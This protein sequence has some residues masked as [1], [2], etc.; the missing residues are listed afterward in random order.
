MTLKKLK[1]LLKNSAITQDEFDEMVA[2]L[3]PEDSPPTDPPSDPSD[4]ANPPTDP[5]EDD[6]DAKIT[7][8]VQAALGQAGKENKE[9]KTQLKLERKKNLTAEELKQVELQEKEAEILKKEQELLNKENRMYAIKSLKKGGLDDGGE[10]ALDFVDFVMAEDETGIDLKVKA[11]SALV[12]KRVKVEVE[13]TF[14]NNGRDPGK[15]NTSGEK[16]NPW[17]KDNWNLTK[18]MKMELENPELA[19]TMKTSAIR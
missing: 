14:R 12:N 7:K 16:G 8:A 1:E 6:L 17:S 19:K 10:D 9:L 11:L 18:Q 2:G 3:K 4:P 5:P 13:K 15:G